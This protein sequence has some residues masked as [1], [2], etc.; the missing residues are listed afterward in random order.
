MENIDNNA[1]D[2]ISLFAQ[3]DP[4]GVWMAILGMG[5]V[6]F[7]LL[8]LYIVFSNTPKLYTT[9]FKSLAGKA[10]DSL[11]SRKKPIVPEVDEIATIRDKEH[12]SGEVSA[13]IAA[14]IHLYRSELHDYQ[15]TALTINK[16]SKTYSPWSSKIY[17]LR[18]VPR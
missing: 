9:D 4:Y 2:Q 5:I 13:A 6:F 3:N 10:R 14:A 1:T 17:G 15:N 7:V 18:K 12:L 16:V 11:F 8:M